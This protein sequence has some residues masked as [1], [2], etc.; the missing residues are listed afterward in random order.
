MTPF[1][2]ACQEG[3]TEMCKIMDEM[4]REAVQEERYEFA[5]NLLNMKKL[6][7]EEITQAANISVEEVEELSKELQAQ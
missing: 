3:V 6:T 5:E 2:P 7:K 4:K 1:V